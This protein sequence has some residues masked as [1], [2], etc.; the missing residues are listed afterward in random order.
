[1]RSGS[2]TPEPRGKGGAQSPGSDS[3]EAYVP[4]MA[5]SSAASSRV[6]EEPLVAADLSSRPK[7]P[8]PSA[9]DVVRDL[10]GVRPQPADEPWVGASKV[11]GMLAFLFI[12]CLGIA[13][14]VMLTASGD[15]SSSG[16]SPSPA[17]IP[18]VKLGSAY[19]AH[20]DPTKYCV[21]NRADNMLHIGFATSSACN[22]FTS[23]TTYTRDQ[24]G[25]EY[26]PNKPGARP[27]AS[28]QHGRSDKTDW[29]FSTTYQL[30]GSCEHYGD[31]NARTN[32][33]MLID[34]VDFRK[35]MPISEVCAK[36]WNGEGDPLYYDITQ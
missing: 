17:V 6:P 25:C 15:S 24:L 28:C 18:R 3:P 26:K 23:K 27:P 13:M 34:K 30:T 29:V 32:A 35:Y 16:A 31:N 19:V 36:G 22:A 11:V 12:F 14:G 7:A 2:S 20:G 8:A 10:L 9:Y 4:M 33:A 21:A 1:M 5:R